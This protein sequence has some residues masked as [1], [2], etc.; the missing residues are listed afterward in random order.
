[1]IFDLRTPKGYTHVSSVIMM[2]FHL[3]VVILSFLEPSLPVRQ[4]S[5][6][7]LLRW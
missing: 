7:L 3:K 4:S 5:L 2:S 6:S 1:M